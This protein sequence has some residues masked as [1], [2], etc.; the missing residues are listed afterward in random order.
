M[1]CYI[2]VIICVHL[3]INV[4]VLVS[5]LGGSVVQGNPDL[6]VDQ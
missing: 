3:F 6:I 5:Q 1:L 2:Y 4:I